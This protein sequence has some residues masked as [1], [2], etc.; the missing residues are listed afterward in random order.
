MINVMVI[1]F[2]RP[3]LDSEI[4][5]YSG[6]NMVGKIL[7]I[8]IGLAALSGCYRRIERVEYREPRASNIYI[9]PNRQVVIERQVIEP[10]SDVVVERH[11][12]QPRSDVII[13]QRTA[14]VR[15]SEYFDPEINQWV[16]RSYKSY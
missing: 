9:E 16:R 8:C 5:Y 15:E 13:E 12:V 4:F 10:R 14:V 3:N 7:S 1:L 11:I 2:I 6:V